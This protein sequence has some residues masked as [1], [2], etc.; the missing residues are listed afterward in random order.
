MEFPFR[1]G[2]LIKLDENGYGV[3]T[4]DI[5]KKFVHNNKGYSSK[6]NP[7]S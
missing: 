5:A 4:S 3:I 2:S 7:F 6:Y 1:I